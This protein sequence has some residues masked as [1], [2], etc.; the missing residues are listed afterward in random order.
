MN[1]SEL[2]WNRSFGG[3]MWNVEIFL[4]SFLCLKPSFWLLLWIK[5]VDKYFFSG[6]FF[7]LSGM[8]QFEKKKKNARDKSKSGKKLWT[9]MLLRIKL[10]LV[11]ILN[12]KTPVFGAISERPCKFQLRDKIYSIQQ[13]INLWVRLAMSTSSVWVFDELWTI[14][15]CR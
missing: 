15:F 13:V 10:S 5:S 14:S 7:C 2:Q 9:W 1:G 6:G 11:L 12:C 4:R 8:A 3:R